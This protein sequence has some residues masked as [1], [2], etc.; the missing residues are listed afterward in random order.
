MNN[1]FLNPI[2]REN[3]PFNERLQKLYEHKNIDTNQRGWAPKVAQEMIDRKIIIIGADYSPKQNDYEK[4]VTKDN[5][6]R[7]LKKHLKDATNPPDMIWIYRYRE[8]FGCSTDY[9][10]GCISSFTPELSDVHDLTGLS[11]AAVQILTEW[12]RI[13]LKNKQGRAGESYILSNLISS[14]LCKELLSNIASCEAFSYKLADAKRDYFD[15][16]SDG[17]NVS[18]SAC[19]AE[20]KDCEHD[21]RYFSSEASRVFGNMIKSICDSIVSAAPGTPADLQ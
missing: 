2:Y 3:H 7:E 21:V 6:A 20:I 5:V 8:Y 1:G 18:L 9:L 12:Q 16:L 4:D 14:S 15:Q 13:A 11:P 17:D 10:F 19:K